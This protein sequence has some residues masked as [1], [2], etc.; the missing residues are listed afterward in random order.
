LLQLKELAEKVQPTPT[1]PIPQPIPPSFSQPILLHNP[2]PTQGFISTPN[3][4]PLG[5]PSNYNPSGDSNFQ[6]LYMNSMDINISSQTCQYGMPH[7]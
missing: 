7:K 3:V 1:F 5:Q 2:F 4:I 6:I